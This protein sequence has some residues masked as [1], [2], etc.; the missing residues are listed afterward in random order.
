[1]SGST[2][3]RV[4]RLTTYGESHG[5]GLGGIIDGCPAGIALDER[6]IQAELDKRRPGQANA[7]A[8]ARKEPDS[9]AILSGVFEGRTTGTP[10]AFHVA[11][12]SQHSADYDALRDIYRPGHADYTFDAKFGCR[13]HR[14]GGRSSGRETVAR[15]AG[16]A[17]AQA[18]LA[19][20]G[21][22]LR[23]CTV[24]FGGILAPLTDVEG[25]GA[26]AF[27]SPDEGTVALWEDA[28]KR[29]K[30]RGDTLGGVVR[31]EALGVPAGLGEPVFDKLDAL[32]AHALMSVGAVKGVA[33][34]D[35]FAAADSTGSANNDPLT[36]EGFASNHGG[37]ILG[38]ISTGQPIILT[39]AVKP[40]ASIPR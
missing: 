9:V 33:V 34:G 19:R 32:F 22:S 24:S 4:F 17:V 13:D 28:V 36:P 7:A 10:I 35:G 31:V 3:G 25:A 18:V 15:V 11:N 14:G 5:P 20:E 16:G 29:A 30:A 40:I 2:F 27:F 38:G 39:A 23:A 12:T 6:M 26:R 8:T 1:M 21:I 37:G